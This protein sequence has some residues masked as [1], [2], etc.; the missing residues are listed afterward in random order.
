LEFLK[1]MCP[2]FLICFMLGACAKNFNS[3][4][5]K[6]P[7]IELEKNIGQSYLDGSLLLENGQMLA[8]SA[9]SDKPVLIYFVGED[10]LACFE[11]TVK[12][13]ELIAENGLPT[14]IYL[15]TVMISVDSQ[16]ITGWFKDIEPQVLKP[17]LLGSDLSLSLYRRYFEVLSTPSILYFQPQSQLLRRW[18]GKQ[19]LEKIQQETG[20]WY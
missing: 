14:Q 20:S 16:V 15:I 5:E 17:W 2:F 19:T 7:V 6:T 4:I 11:E 9:L 12:L 3:Q 1:R 13:K 18:Q 10:C 8:L